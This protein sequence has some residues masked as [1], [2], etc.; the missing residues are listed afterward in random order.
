MHTVALSTW[1]L[2]IVGVLGSAGCSEEK[3]PRMRGPESESAR[4]A[5]GGAGGTAAD[6]GVVTNG[7]APALSC[8]S[9][10]ATSTCDPVTAWPC[11]VAAGETCDYSNLAGAFRCYALPTANPVCGFCDQESAFCGPGTTCGAGRCERY[12]CDDSD[13][14]SG[15]CVRDLFGDPAVAAV[16]YCPEESIALC[17]VNPADIEE[18]PDSNA[19]S[20]ASDAGPSD[21]RGDTAAL[22]DAGQ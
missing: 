11:D 6:A 1:A 7:A 8:G 15:P 5:A 4:L 14:A 3:G 2:L 12:C 13:C 16:G 20:N 10:I 17:G 21:A 9:L 22:P 18:V 19:A